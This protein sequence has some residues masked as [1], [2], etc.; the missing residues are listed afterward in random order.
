ML[1]PQA[2]VLEQRSRRR[3][4]SQ[5]ESPSPI[6]SHPPQSLPSISRPTSVDSNREE[7]VSN[8][9][10][11]APR[12]PNRVH[13]TPRSPTLHRAQSL[14]VLNPP[15]GTIDA[16]QS[17]F[18]STSTRPY[19]PEPA[20]TQPTVSSGPV[21]IRAAYFPS[22]A[23][24]NPTPPPGAIR[25][26]FRRPSMSFPQSG[27]A[28]PIASFSPYSQPASVASSQFETSSQQGSYNQMSNNTPMRDSHAAPI[29]ME[30]D[31]NSMAMAPPGQERGMIPMSPSGQ[32]SIQI[33]TI[34]SQ[35]GYDVHIPV[36][37]QA[38]SK[39]ADEKRKRNA[40]ASARFRAR[41]KEKEREASMSIA[42]LEQQLRDA[43][44]DAEFYRGEREYF[45]SVMFQQPG[46]DRHFT[47]P[48]SPRLRRLS[49]PSI[50]PS[51]TADA[52]SN[53]PYSPYS[54][55]G[56]VGEARE[57]ERNVRRR[58]SSYHPASGPPP[59]QMNGSAPHQHGYTQ[60]HFPPMNTPMLHG[61]P[62][63]RPPPQFIDRRTP[64]ELQAPPSQR[65]VLHDP[66]AADSAR[67]DSR[68]WGPGR[69]SR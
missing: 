49:V 16:H 55:I 43:L 50:T 12:L 34:Q 66:F 56:D 51:S 68:N 57:S 48:Q 60:A 69:D 19:P 35:Q 14:S 11:F 45:K 24:T 61:P 39:V 32:S 4:A 3:S 40:G 37:V 28:S 1:N 53:S 2:E 6:E 58:T 9:P 25:N 42:R 47:R 65:P 18:L 52:G 10:F 22:H 46:A 17:P 36:D 23:P 31:R 67:H 41:R 27:S 29:V 8:R 38:A 30:T 5:M 64:H 15:T 59:S 7:P 21:G 33:M 63:S 54:E 44:E 26:D 62:S 13:L 20:T